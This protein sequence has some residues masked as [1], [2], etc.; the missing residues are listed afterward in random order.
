[1][2]RPTVE[3]L[4]L[5]RAHLRAGR[6]DAALETARHASLIDDSPALGEAL[7]EFAAAHA[8]VA[9]A[10]LLGE[11]AMR[12]PH[13]YDA[14]LALASALHG[15]GRLGDA[16]AWA[17]RAG[18]LRPLERLPREI[19][20][21]AL[22]DRGDVER[23]LALFRELLPD[24]DAATA[25]RY[26]VLMHYD[27]AATNDELFAR[28]HAFAR[29]HLP[30]FGTPFTRSVERH[31][32]R[33]LRIGWLS[34][35]FTEGPVATFLANLLGAFDRTR[36]RQLLISLQPA[37]D[38]ATARFETLADEWIVLAGLDDTTLLQRLRAL[39]LDVLVDLAGHSTANRIGVVAQRV[40]P[41][42]VSWLDWFDTTAVPAMDAW[43]S[44]ARLTPENSTQRYTERVMRLASG[45]FCYSPPRDAPSASYAGDGVTV[46][47]SFNRL[48]KLNAELVAAWAS[49]LRRVP[50]SRLELGARLLGDEAT[51][52]YTRE[53]FAAHGI[54]AGRLR[55]HG[56]RTY[57]ALLAAY[58]SVDIALDPFPFS[59][60]TT[61]C[62][63]LYMGAAVIARTGETF[64]SR[65]SASLLE[66]LGREEWIARDAVDY[67]ERAVAA[68]ADVEALRA[69]RETQ[70][71]DV[72]A[73]L[74]DSAAQARDFAAAF[75]ELIG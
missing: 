59:G 54:D 69:A 19:H 49:I 34:P 9:H 51:R 31:G 27:P 20:A 47:A 5:V 38:D 62:D 40:A 61:T 32:R 13:D 15:L 24:A 45:R 3:R 4:A 35:R 74:C 68:S 55:L 14:A 44:D 46:F 65:Q 48:A 52:A 18:A 73:K 17:E 29:T 41:I 1:M 60:C 7:H 58:G 72:V 12:H 2:E 71:R 43:I 57:P 39:E 25:A 26:L 28:L 23:G 36:H 56:Q 10:M 67:V 22:V 70:R 33:R 37:R 63:A 64:V 8:F 30:R 66:R 11:R 42:Q 21:T 6:V 50:G 75:G 53:R 16:I